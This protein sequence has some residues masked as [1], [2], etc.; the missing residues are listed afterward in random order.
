MKLRTQKNLSQQNSP[1]KENFL[2]R[3]W[4]LLSAQ[5]IKP[6]KAVSAFIYKRHSRSQKG[7]HSKPSFLQ[8]LYSLR[9]DISRQSNSDRHQFPES[10]SPLLQFFLF[11]GGNFPYWVSRLREKIRFRRKRRIHLRS[12]L[13][14]VFERIRLHPA[15]FL[16]GALVVAAICALLSVFTVGVTVNYAGYHL[17]NVSGRH[18]VNIAVSDI[19]KITRE[20]LQD[21]NYTV[22]TSALELERQILPRRTMETRQELETQLTGQLGLVQYAH[23]LY[24]DGSPVVATTYDDALEELLEQLKI[25]YI[26]PNTVDCHFEED[27]EIREEYIESSYVMNL[28]YI[29]EILNDTKSAEVTYTVVANDAPESIAAKFDVS[30]DSLK[31]TNPGYD[32]SILHV[33]DVLTIS[34]AVPYL[35]VVNVERQDYLQDVP[36][37][38][39]YQDNDSMYQGEYNVL[40]KGTFGKAD[41]SANVSYMNGEEVKREVVSSVTLT[42]PVTELQERGTKERP[43]WFPTGSFGWPCNGTI[44]SRFGYRNTGIRGASTYHEG[45]DI[46]NGY[47]TPIYAS[48]GGTVTYSGWQGGYGYLVIIDHGNGY[49]TYYGHNSSL[50][51]SVGDHV[52]KGQQI[53]KMGSTGV[54]SGNHCD[55]RI[56]LNGTF[57]NP[58]NY[59]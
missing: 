40:S 1:E 48:D 35:T 25:G 47:G 51:V 7:K 32:W 42:Q 36:Y 20:T 53:A 27:V 34:N 50:L 39:E 12:S 2:S 23:V 55:F 33:G 58:L 24:I 17:G 26:T 19:E 45:I 10:E 41:V 37:D 9:R 4:H 57:L 52:Y 21:L 8:S 11:V 3:L 14:G 54:S 28:G 31:K 38:V 49:Q 56:K 44:T 29:A 59:L 13:R 5:L 15:V 6:L 46:A 43:S 22:D 16:S 18:A 30:L